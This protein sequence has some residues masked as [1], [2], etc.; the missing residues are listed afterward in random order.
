MKKI[1]VFVLFLFVSI[2]SVAQ[3]N[4]TVK[5]GFWSMG[6]S[7]C[8]SFNN[9]SANSFSD[10]L[11]VIWGQDTVPSVTWF[12][13]GTSLYPNASALDWNVNSV[14]ELFD[15]ILYRSNG[16]IIS[17]GSRVTSGL[18]RGFGHYRMMSIHRWTVSPEFII[19]IQGENDTYHDYEAAA[20]EDNLRDFISGVRALIGRHN[21][22]FILVELGAPYTSPPPSSADPET[23]NAAF[24]TIAAEDPEN[25][26]VL[27]M[28]DMIPEYYEEYGIP[29]AR[30]V[31]WNSIGGVF[32]AGKLAALIRNLNW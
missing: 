2:C 27:D 30:Y 32:V 22:K 4:V 7:N 26:V 31:H 6:Q 28:S 29:G 13:G 24:A 14:G 17:D 23:I 8:L 3:I 12:R 15:S 5:K 25:I 10:S 20:Y 9:F 1:L 11:E 21:M 16:Y 19:W 18:F